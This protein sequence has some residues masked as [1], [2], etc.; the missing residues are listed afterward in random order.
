MRALAV[1]L[2]ALLIASCSRAPA[3]GNETAGP[4]QP[5]WSGPGAGPGA[6]AGQPEGRIDRSHA[7][8]PAPAAAFDDPQGRSTSLSDFRGR[9]LLVNLWATW[10]APCVTELPT[11]DSLA[12][13]EDGKLQVLAISLDSEGRAKVDPF[14]AEHGYKA[15]EPYVDPKMGLMP[16]LGVDTLPTTI[17]YDSSGREVWRMVGKKDWGSADS[18]RL[19]AEASGG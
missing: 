1:L 9:P 12:G 10:C 7:G 2:P 17:L 6:A 14:F 3:N 13:R 11:L 5:A 18:K 8:K 15:L 16:E 19:I 4:D